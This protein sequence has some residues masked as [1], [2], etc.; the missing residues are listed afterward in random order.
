MPQV[1]QADRADEQRLSLFTTTRMK[2]RSSSVS[3]GDPPPSK[4]KTRSPLPALLSPR[5]SPRRALAD[6]TQQVINTCAPAPPT[7]PITPR[8]HRV[9]RAA[10]A[11]TTRLLSVSPWWQPQTAQLSLR[12]PSDDRSECAPMA[13]ALR[14]AGRSH[15]SCNEHSI[16][17]TSAGRPSRHPFQSLRRTQSAPVTCQSSTSDSNPLL[18]SRRFRVHP[19]A[20]QRVLL[21]QWMGVCRW[22]YNRASDAIN[23]HTVPATVPALQKAFVNNDNYGD[24]KQWV[25]DVPTALRLAAVCDVVQ[26]ANAYRAKKPQNQTGFHLKYRSVRDPVQ[27]ITV[28]KDKWNQQRSDSKYSSVFS[29]VALRGGRDYQELLCNGAVTYIHRSI[30]NEK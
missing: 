30:Q 24:D 4:R 28:R 11:F 1:V 27:S 26:A 29:T 22:T 5:R 21:R 15:W 9:R 23:K 17:R 10:T 25:K 18:R 20:E 6:I 8:I 16:M 2:R 14:A 13:G 12:L 7:T 19:T 3:T